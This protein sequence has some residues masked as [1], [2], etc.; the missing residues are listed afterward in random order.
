MDYYKLAIDNISKFGDTDI[1]PYPIEN[2]LFYDKPE[3]VKKILEQISGDFDNWSTNYPVESINSC[4]PVG[5]TGFRWAAIVDP[6]WNAF[7]LYEVLRISKD[8]E[9]KRIAPSKNCVFSYRL[10]L[11]QT[12]GKLFDN[13]LTWRKFYETARTKASSSAYVIKLDISDFYTRIYHH[14]LEN[15]LLRSTSNTTSVKRIMTILNSIS[16]N[17]SYGLPVGGNAA[18][19][20]AETLLNSFDQVI[21]SKKIDFCRYVDD[22][23]IFADSKEDAFKKLNWC[24]EFLLRNEGLTLQKNKTQILTSSEFISQSTVIL[25]GEDDKEGKER[26]AF[27]RIHIKYDPYS[28]TAEQ[29]YKELKRKLSDFDIV[30]LIKTEIRKSRIH[31]AF[32]KQLLNA[33]NILEDEPLNLAFKTI[34]SN[35]DS[36]YPIYPSVMHLA[37]R[38]LLDCDEE[39]I[40][41]FLD[42]LAE[43]VFTDSYIVQTD[44]NSSYT[45]RVLS[46]KN[47][48]SSI[49]AIDHIAS[50]SRSALVKMN[51]IY[52][53]TNL[54]NSFW[55]SDLKPQF[56]T[57][58]S[59]ERRAFIAASYYLN[60]EGK[61]WRDKIEPQLSEFET[62]LKRWIGSK[63]PSASNWKLPL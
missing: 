58:T 59:W 40:D 2:A 32:G 62:L 63:N 56:S 38:K 19:I 30:P 52:G 21:N 20:L 7:L 16:K 33:V 35:L 15:A 4:I 11:K 29:D 34:A 51:C 23:I 55:L 24:A 60:D 36:F 42:T 8:L 57:F 6:I 46:L 61:H 44:N 13:D 39:T 28:I 48:E 22:Y 1:F 5:I 37:N 9:T 54:S 49:Q 12:T 47:R 27:M 53:M 50:A 17:A 3:E 14:R 18:R 31:H 10:K 43:L 45:A 25:E 41:F 26:S